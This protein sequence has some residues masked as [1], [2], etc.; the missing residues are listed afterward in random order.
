MKYL[1]ICESGQCSFTVD[2]DQWS[3]EVEECPQCGGLSLCTYGS[4]RTETE[5]EDLL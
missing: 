3:D 4:G 1:K 5:G 2:S